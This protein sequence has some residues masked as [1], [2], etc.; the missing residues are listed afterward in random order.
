MKTCKVVFNNKIYEAEE[1]ANAGVFL[2]ERGLTGLVCGGHGRCGKCRVICRGCVSAP[3]D[4]EK[5]VLSVKELDSGVRLA[6]QTYITG[7][8]EFVS[9]VS[10][11]AEI[12]ADGNM[13]QIEL[14]PLFEK[15]GIAVDIGTT[16]VALRLYD[17][18]GALIASASALN[19][20][21]AYGAD[22]VTR[23]EA[24]L[25]GAAVKLSE[26]I[27]GVLCDMIRAASSDAGI[28]TADIDGAV[29]AG[30]TVMLSFLTG[31][32]TEPLTHAPFDAKRLFG[33]TVTAKSLGLDVLVSSTPVYLPRCISAFVGA[34]ITCAVMSSQIYKN[35]KN[36]VLTDIGTNG[37]TVLKRKNE[38]YACS[39][40]AGPAFE[41]AGIS[42]G[43]SGSD[44]AVDRVSVKD[45]KLETH[46]I[47]GGKPVG[48]CGSGIVDA[49]AAL[50]EV[51][52]IDETGY[53]E[54]DPAVIIPPVVITQAD[55]RAVQLAKSA[56]H[57][58]I[59]TL[60][61][62]AGISFSDIERFYIAGGFGSYLDVKN[63]GRIGLFPDEM[64][65][66]VKV[67]GNASLAGA[68]AMLLCSSLLD[69]SEAVARS[70][71]TAEL[72]ADPVFAEEYMENMTF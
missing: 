56:I 25:K 31:T 40:A 3:T 67:L 57:A 35:E 55:I 48:I 4:R 36:A 69:E 22:V 16:T 30:N 62:H 45:G 61:S 46:V 7:D 49:V 21:R 19:P 34:D 8:C 51:D 53:M 18:N 50:L 10:G 63:A 71:K 59:K 12:Q 54:D 64:T 66:C 11:K 33:E 37:E 47:G 1:G 29:I 23:M 13:P 44:G 60:L 39:T 9:A 20:Q 41:G 38:L 58:G 5:E 17:K 65:G 68:S 52:A 28:K 72:A 32:D 24:A 42:M 26:V 43:M 14:K 27:R 15:Y 70:I 6:C 2:R